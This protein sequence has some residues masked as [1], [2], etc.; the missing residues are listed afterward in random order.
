MKIME[1]II[2]S[3]KALTAAFPCKSQEVLRHGS[4]GSFVTA[5]MAA[6]LEQVAHDSFVWGPMSG[7]G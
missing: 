1:G 4:H 6:V 5:R 3:C 7:M 2:S